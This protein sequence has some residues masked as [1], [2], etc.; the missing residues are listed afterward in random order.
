M[1]TTTKTSKIFHQHAACL[2]HYGFVKLSEQ[3]GPNPANARRISTLSST[4]SKEKLGVIAVDHLAHTFLHDGELWPAGKNN[5]RLEEYLTAAIQRQ[6]ASGT[7]KTAKATKKTAQKK[8]KASKKSE[9]SG[10][11]FITSS[12]VQPELAPEAE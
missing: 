2:Q 4:W 5:V 10:N 8:S 3:K 6:E 11:E 12:E 7:K 9:A 1:E